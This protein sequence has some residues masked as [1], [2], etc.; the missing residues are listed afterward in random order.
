LPEK[1]KT[2]KRQRITDQFSIAPLNFL[3]SDVVAHHKEIQITASLIIAQSGAPHDLRFC[4]TPR[5]S[6]TNGIQ[7]VNNN[8]HSSS[9]F[10]LRKKNFQQ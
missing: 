9:I 4:S 1:L 6:T 5:V 3:T 7:D 2:L 8:A 10:E